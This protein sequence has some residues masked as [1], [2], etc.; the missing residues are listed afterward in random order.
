MKFA[1]TMGQTIAYL[2]EEVKPSLAKL[3]LNF[4]D[5]LPSLQ[6]LLKV[7]RIVIEKHS[8]IPWID[9]WIVTSA[10]PH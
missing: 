4:N 6:F 2:S 8:L 3:L 7:L 5:D 9:N 1:M 10:H